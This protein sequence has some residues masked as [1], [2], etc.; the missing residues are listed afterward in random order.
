MRICC[1]KCLVK[2]VEVEVKVEMDPWM[3]RHRRDAMRWEAGKVG[4]VSSRVSESKYEQC[5]KREL[6]L[7]Q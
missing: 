3:R 6:D 2:L 1:C 4:E 7:E 5:V